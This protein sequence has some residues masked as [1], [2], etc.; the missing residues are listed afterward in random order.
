MLK[1][2]LDVGYDRRK[3]H[4]LWCRVSEERLGCCLSRKSTN[5]VCNFPS[6]QEA[7]S[8]ATVVSGSVGQG[9]D[10]AV[11]IKD[12]GGHVES[13]TGGLGGIVGAGD[14]VAGRV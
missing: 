9:D 1:L 4:R 6:T 2:A 7:G 5:R 11:T 8:A 13:L 14:A 10:Q 12:R 3:Y